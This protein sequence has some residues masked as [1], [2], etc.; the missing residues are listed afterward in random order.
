VG[1]PSIREAQGETRAQV[2][3]QEEKKQGGGDG[4][5]QGRGGDETSGFTKRGQDKGRRTNKKKSKTDQH[6]GKGE[7]R[8]LH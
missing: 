3:P 6:R 7:R 8:H 2:N 5:K 1:T 4:K